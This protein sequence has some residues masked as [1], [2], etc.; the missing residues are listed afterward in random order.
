M[1]RRSSGMALIVGLLAASAGLCAQAAR[2]PDS[3]EVAA[4][5]R[6]ALARAKILD[7]VGVTRGVNGLLSDLGAKVT[8]KQIQIALSADVLFDFD[9]FSLRPEATIALQ[10]VAEVLKSYA[11]A[12]V[13]IEGHTDGKGDAAYNMTLSDRRAEAVKRW[14]TSPGEVEAKRMSSKGWGK[15]RPVAPNTTPD[16]ADDPAGRQKNRRVEIT[17]TKPE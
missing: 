14:L 5:A 8:D 2:D 7:V 6:A 3:P 9:S 13:L 10:K 15:T 16:G 11:P 4:A 12:P 1:R 17:V